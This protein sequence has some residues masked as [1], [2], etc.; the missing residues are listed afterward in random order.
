M[1]R[2]VFLLAVLLPF[3]MPAMA[4]DH[5]HPNSSHGAQPQHP[6]QTPRPKGGPAHVVGGGYIPSHGP[7]VSRPLPRQPEPGQPRAPHVDAN[8]GHWYGHTT[9]NDTAYH[10]DRPWEHGHF[11]R[12]IGAQHV[13]RLVG[14]GPDRFWFGGY[15]FSV[16]PTDIGYC[17]GW[18][19]D[20]DDIILYPDP[21]HDGWYLAYNV[22]L[23]IYVHV[24]FL[25]T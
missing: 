13:W 16:A 20:S 11:P 5:G 23:G 6:V 25:G 21:D 24:M 19:W 1:K 14:G 7:R 10:L 9:R 8:T 4:Q 12:P 18:L 15:Y 22:R 17:D 3:T 2:L